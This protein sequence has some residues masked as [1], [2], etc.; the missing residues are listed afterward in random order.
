MQTNNFQSII[1][2]NGVY[3]YI[4]HNYV[5]GQLQWSG[6]GK[7]K[8]VVGYVAVGGYFDSHPAS[9]K[10]IIHDIIS[11]STE[12]KRQRRKRQGDQKSKQTE[13]KMENESNPKGSKGPAD[14]DEEMKLKECDDRKKLVELAAFRNARDEIDVENIILNKLAPD[15][16]ACPK[17]VGQAEKDEG[18]FI[19]QPDE[20]MCFISTGP[21][22]YPE[23]Y[24]TLTVTQ[25][26]CYSQNG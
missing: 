11:C 8:A 10:S 6:I 21:N 15:L 26:C 13:M 24:K 9:E 1:A 7:D 19:K 18:R 20:P 17:S 25:Q 5:C 3:T 16:N 14:E 2:T 22:R 23:D 4:I 12:T